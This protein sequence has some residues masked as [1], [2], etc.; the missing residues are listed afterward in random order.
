MQCRLNF[1]EN[2][3][4]SLHPYTPAESDY[5]LHKE[6]KLKLILDELQKKED[7]LMKEKAELEQMIRMID[8]I[9]ALHNKNT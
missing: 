9:Q 4:I 7:E 3:I 1:S 2:E 5:N 8:L 6:R